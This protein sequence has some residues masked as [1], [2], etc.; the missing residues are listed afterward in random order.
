MNAPRKT[1]FSTV[2]L[3]AC[4]SVA[5]AQEA[6][7]AKRLFHLDSYH[8]GYSISDDTATG[9][10]A[11][12]AGKPVQ[13]EHFYL[14][15]KRKTTDAEIQES[16]ARARAAIDKFK[17]DVLVASDDAAVKYVVVPFYKNGPYPVVYCG[18]NWSSEAYALPKTQA[19]GM[20]EV[21]PILEALDL[22][23]RHYPGIKR[24]GVL[25]ED[26]LSERGNKLLLEPKYRALGLEVTSVLVTDYASWKRELAR[27][28]GA[29]DVLYLPTQGAVKGWDAADAKAFVRTTLKKPTVAT[30]EFMMPY[31]LLGLV[32]SQV[33]QGEFAGRAALEILAGKKTADIP[34]ARNRRRKAYVNL[35]LAKALEF[36]PGADLA[37]AITVH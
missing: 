7:A 18:V 6:P 2:V 34:E 33:E 20:I 8:Q 9:L 1:V 29:V 32:K 35:T 37:G 23:R 4:T 13:V 16:A 30:D 21:S 22:V 31:A 36:V 11:V 19:T 28:Q 14:D 10:S 26:S 27:L 24:L 12:L 3:A 17:P 5:A 15:T 25:T